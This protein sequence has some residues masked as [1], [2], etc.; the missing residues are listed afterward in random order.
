MAN[1]KIAVTGCAG[2]M[3]QALI[4]EIAGT[5]GCALAGGSE[6]KNSPNVGQDPGELAGIGPTGMA[7]IDS[8][9]DIF[10]A[11]DVV[12]DFT[13]PEAA[14]RHVALAAETGTVLVLGTT[15]LDHDQE[16]VVKQAAGRATIV[17]A[18]NMSLGINLLLEITRQLAGVLGP[19]FDIEIHE[20]HHRHKV[21]APSGTALALGEAAAAGRGVILDEVAARGR[22]GHTG[23]RWPGSIGF[24]VTRGG[25]LAGEHTVAFLADNERIELTHRAGDRSIFARGAVRAALWAHGRPAGLYSM[26]DVLGFHSGD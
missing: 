25:N 11:A 6:H 4:R 26:A 1:I 18:L 12:L 22:D 20:A 21:D 14:L 7:I 13:T 15:G 8:A 17:R 19:E 2:R 24:S 9:Q 10:A 3:G 23:V 16:E 5:H